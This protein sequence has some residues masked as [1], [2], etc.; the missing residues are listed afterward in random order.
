MMTRDSN[1]TI[2]DAS[3]G[4]TRR[5]GI[6]LL[7]L[8]SWLVV[9]VMVSIYLVIEYGIFYSAILTGMLK[10]MFSDFENPTWGKIADIIPSV[11]EWTT[12]DRMD[13]TGSALLLPSNSE[14]PISDE[15]S[16]RCIDA[17]SFEGI[18]FGRNR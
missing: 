14:R 13:E 15:E 18:R 17:F 1:S 6:V 9:V 11:Q 7:S 5:L 16:S 12:R 8:F 10:K 4:Q 3:E 2:L